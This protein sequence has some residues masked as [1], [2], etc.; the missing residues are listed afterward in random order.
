MDPDPCLTSRYLY[1]HL[2]EHGNC[3]RVVAAAASIS[4]FTSDLVTIGSGP[5]A[6]G[7]L[8][9]VSEIHEVLR[10]PREELLPGLPA[11]GWPWTPTLGGLHEK[12]DKRPRSLSMA[13]FS[14]VSRPEAATVTKALAAEW[15]HLFS[16]SL[17]FRP[18][19]RTFLCQCPSIIKSR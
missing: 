11:R 13:R 4:V 9:E 15:E 2:T 5:F 16:D 1:P 10:D 12:A 19:C 14:S 3:L 8:F 18:H 7:P 17:E 6:D